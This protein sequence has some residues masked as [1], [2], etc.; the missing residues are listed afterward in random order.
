MCVAAAATSWRLRRRARSGSTKE[1]CALSY[2]SARMG[3]LLRAAQGR[4]P[5]DTAT[6]IVPVPL[7]AERERER[8]FNQAARLARSLAT[9]S[10]LPLDEWSVVRTAHTSLHR[11]GM[12]A[13]ARRETVEGAFQVE[14][15]RLIAGER[16]LLVDD[17]L[18]TGAT[19]SSCAQA[20][21]AA[22]AEDV[23]VLT[24]A[25]A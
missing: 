11:A 23:F 16:I 8:G 6:R 14:R 17:V 15:P 4:A 21:K 1:L 25:Q 5:L 7:H 18:T 19:V 12:D 22:G 13:R 20:L 2:V 10:R 9:L 3:Q 24:V